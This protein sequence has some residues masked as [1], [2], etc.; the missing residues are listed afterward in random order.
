MSTNS[1]RLIKSH[2]AFRAAFGAFASLL[3]TGAANV[4]AR[5]LNPSD[6]SLVG[7]SSLDGISY[8]SVVD[9]N[10]NESFLLTSKKSDYGLTLSV[11]TSSYD[12]VIEQNGRAVILKMGYPAGGERTAPEGLI[13]A[14]Q[15]IAAAEQPVTNIPTPPP[16]TELPLVFQ[17][18]DT[19]KFKLSDEQHALIGRLRQKFLAAVNS[20][21]STGTA[22][23][24]EAPAAV[25]VAANAP[26][27]SAP[28]LN[29]PP[30]T[31]AW[32]SAQRDSDAEFKMLYGYDAFNRLQMGLSK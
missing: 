10:T 1:I 20:S 4:S 13:H 32:R 2:R 27:T 17:A 23:A 28:V 31:K 14:A 21:N 26:D 3:I 16:G 8:V 6:L 11:V 24:P 12:A 9:Q 22:S 19:Q 18:N 5:D 15:P 30:Q 7:V 25:P 29:D